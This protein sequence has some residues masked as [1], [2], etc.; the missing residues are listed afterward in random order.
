MN[1]TEK[2]PPEI[3]TA[4]AKAQGAM[5]RVAHDNRNSHHGY[6]YTSAEAVIEAS[7]GPMSQAGLALVQCGWE[8]LAPAVDVWHDVNDKGEPTEAKVSGPARLRIRYVLVS[9]S[10]HS[11]EMPAVTMPVLPEKGRP[12]DKAEATALTYSLGYTLRGLLKIPRTDDG[13]DL[14]QRDDATAKRGPVQRPAQ[15]G[16]AKAKAPATLK[17]CETR[18]EF[19]AWVDANAQ[20]LGSLSDLDYAREMEAVVATA[21]RFQIPEKAVRD[22]VATLAGAVPS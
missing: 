8:P 5:R 1:E 20:R 17:L 16:T 21:D 15:N 11:W 3:A 22:R 10:G 2:M 9:E 4:I 14:D 7:I 6:R 19:T 18:A 13:D 12:I